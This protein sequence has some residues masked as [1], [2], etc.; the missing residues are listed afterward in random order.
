MQKPA[1]LFLKSNFEHTR[2]N[3]RKAVKLLNSCPS[4]QD[5][6]QLAVFYYNN[7]GVI[8]FHVCF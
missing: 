3:N 8:H 4:L 7:L 1:G 6:P 5:D 2:G